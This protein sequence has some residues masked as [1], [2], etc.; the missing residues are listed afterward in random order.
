MTFI[1]RF[2]II[3]TR[4]NKAIYEIAF[5]LA[6]L[7]GL[8]DGEGVI[9]VVIVEVDGAGDDDLGKAKIFAVPFS[10]LDSF[11][12]RVVVGCSSTV[13]DSSENR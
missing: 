5:I 1:S 9:D 4:I 8:G 2:I 12:I 7:L 6:S 10:T 11:E 3:L 13:T